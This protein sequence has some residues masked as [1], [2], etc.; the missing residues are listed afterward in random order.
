M[1]ILII[2]GS[3]FIGFHLTQKLV[4]LG[5]NITVLDRNSPVDEKR[6]IGATYVE[7]DFSD[8]ELISELVEAHDEIVHLAYASVPNTSF[9]HPLMDLE[10]NLRPA[11]QLFNIVAEKGARLMLVSSGGTVYG[12]AQSIP[13]SEKHPTQ[14]ISPYGVTKLTLEKY[15]YLY[16]VTRGLKFVCIRPANPYGEGQ[17]PFVGQGFVSTAMALAMRGDPVTIFGK[18]GTIRDYI[19]I[20]DLI[21]GMLIILDRGENKGIYNIGTSIGR[22][23]LDVVQAM[24]PLLQDYGVSVQINC[25]IARSFDVKENILDCTKLRALGWK[26]EVNFDEGLVRL[27]SWLKK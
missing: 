19:Y 17:R 20:D 26:P 24:M 2:G 14:P 25:E 22:S 8:I 13:I 21:E 3:G 12:E 4:A 6:V 9:E 27:L 11:V 16:A 5:R 18:Q 7:G 10:E 15:A 1:K 23:N